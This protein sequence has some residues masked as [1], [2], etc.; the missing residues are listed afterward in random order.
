QTRWLN[1]LVTGR[2][3][4]A[5]RLVRETMEG[6]GENLPDAL[7]QA[8]NMQLGLI[9][10]AR[11]DYPAARQFFEVAIGTDEDA[12]FGMDQILVLTLSA[13]VSRHLG[14]E[15][16]ATKRLLVAER[17]IK[18]ARLNGVDDADIYYS[19]GALLAM[20]DEV[21]A[22]LQKLQQAYDRGFRDLW[23]LKLDWR[24]NS[25]RA[26]QGFVALESRLDQDIDQANAEIRALSVASL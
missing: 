8:F 22:A 18:R 2:Y 7:N 13:L 21:P 20:R 1:L 9:A 25:L 23:L 14:D 3:E 24:L 12:A 5:E 6:A 17:E 4:E 11:L 10:L 26:E 15:A 16:T 19:E